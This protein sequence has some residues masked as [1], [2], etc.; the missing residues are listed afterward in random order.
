MPSNHFIL[1]HPLL[2]LPSIFSSIR[3]FSFS[4]ISSLHQ[5]ANVLEF[6]LQHQS[7][8]WT[9]RTYLLYIYILIF[10]LTQRKGHRVLQIQ[11]QMFHWKKKIY[12][13]LFLKLKHSWYKLL[14]D[15]MEAMLCVFRCSVTSDSVTPWTV[16]LQAPL[17]MEFSR[18]EY[19]SGQPFPSARDLPNPGIKPG[20]PALQMNSLLP[21]PPGKLHTS[22]MDFI[23][24]WLYSP[25]C[26]IYPCRLFYT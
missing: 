24:Y 4:F 1:S 5:M 26:T 2:F 21:E 20:S 3:V 7:F 9:P 11:N 13:A 15:I 14:C 19:W 25:C 16:A 6:Q 12:N 10:S 22:F 18:Q 23:K 17:F 8:Q